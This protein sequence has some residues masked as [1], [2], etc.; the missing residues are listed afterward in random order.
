MK[1][2]ANTLEM[3]FDHRR[4]RS[5]HLLSQ[6]TLTLER[7]GFVSAI[8]LKEQAEAFP[9]ELRGCPPTLSR[10]SALHSEQDLPSGALKCRVLLSAQVTG[11][12]ARVVPRKPSTMYVKGLIR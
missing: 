9:A 5:L 3:R 1:V 12:L 7:K 10:Y 11:V 2:A 8:G 4:P 6:L